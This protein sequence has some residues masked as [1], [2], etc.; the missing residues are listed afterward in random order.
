MYLIV[1]GRQLEARSQCQF[2]QVYFE[3]DRAPKSDRLHQETFSRLGNF[4]DFA[5]SP[6]SNPP[7]LDHL[8]MKIIYI[9][10]PITLNALH[11]RTEIYFLM[12]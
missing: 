2:H 9:H 1:V 8:Q 5:S 6:E 12:I 3:T 11:C 10:S 7:R 4:A